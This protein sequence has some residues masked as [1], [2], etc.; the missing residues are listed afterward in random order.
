MSVSFVD[1]EQIRQLNR[2]VPRQGRRHRC[3]LLPVGRERLSTTTTMK[4]ARICWATSSSRCRARIE[5]AQMY[6]HSLRREIGFLTVHSMLHLLGYD[7]EGGGLEAL[8]M[9]E[10]EELVLTR[11]G[12]QRD[13]E[14]CGRGR[15]PGIA[16]TVFCVPLRAAG[17]GIWQGPSVRSAICAFT[18]QRRRWC[19][20]GGAFIPFPLQRMRP[21]F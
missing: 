3:P 20:M 4:P 12:L 7:H 13:N 11:L 8:R 1:N 18:W 9:R 16:R 19:C 17:S 2:G 5:Q 10:K 14:L 6:G 15:C 21:C